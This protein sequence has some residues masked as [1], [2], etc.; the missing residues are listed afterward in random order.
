MSEPLQIETE[1]AEAEWLVKE[2]A[3][4]LVTRKQTHGN[5]PLSYDQYNRELAAMEAARKH[6]ERAKTFGVKDPGTW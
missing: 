5:A 1:H 4:C 3:R 6:L 2:L